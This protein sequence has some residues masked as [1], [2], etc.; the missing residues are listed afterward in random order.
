MPVHY[1]RHFWQIFRRTIQLRSTANPQHNSNPSQKLHP[2][3]P[4]ISLPQALW[5]D[6]RAL[7]LFS[8]SGI[9]LQRQHACLLTDFEAALMC[10]AEDFTALRDENG[11]QGWEDGGAMEQKWKGEKYVWVTK[12][13]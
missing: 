7:S 3:E 1:S 2:S 12:G 10:F 13:T 4:N 9:A 8:G 6:D 5:A 11:K